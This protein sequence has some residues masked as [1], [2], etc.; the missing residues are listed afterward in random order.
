MWLGQD[1]ERLHMGKTSHVKI[2]QVLRDLSSRGRSRRIKRMSACS[3]RK[4]KF[5]RFLDTWG[6]HV[7]V[8]KTL[9]VLRNDFFNGYELFLA[10]SFPEWKHL[11]KESSTQPNHHF[12][13][14]SGRAS[15]TP[16]LL[17]TDY[18]YEKSEGGSCTK[19]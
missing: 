11:T 16:D 4:P 13:D 5:Y 12:D 6:L 3:L 9:V 1:F 2:S 7:S 10:P 17:V 14:L 15:V 18:A 8:E 19:S